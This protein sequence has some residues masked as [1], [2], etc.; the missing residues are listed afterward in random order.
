MRR[1]NNLSLVKTIIEL[2]MIKYKQY[3]PSE[4][5]NKLSLIQIIKNHRGGRRGVIVPTHLG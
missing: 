3:S 2:S 1:I 4:N 5:I